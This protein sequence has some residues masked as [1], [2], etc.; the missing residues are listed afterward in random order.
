MNTIAAFLND[1]AL[2]LCSPSQLAPVVEIEG[3]DCFVQEEV[4]DR[5]KNSR[6]SDWLAFQI[7]KGRIAQHRL[8]Q[9]EDILLVTQVQSKSGASRAEV[10]SH[11]AA[12]RENGIVIAHDPRVHELL[13]PYVPGVEVIVPEEFV[14]GV[15]LRRAAVFSIA[16]TSLPLD[17]LSTRRRFQ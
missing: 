12:K 7:R 14:G 6:C 2:H 5:I 13:S 3:Y 11:V 10:C 15:A 8:T 16:E 4:V 9:I 17:S 1:S